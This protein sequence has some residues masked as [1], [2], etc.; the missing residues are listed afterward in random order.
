MTVSLTTDLIREQARNALTE[1]IGTGDITA[2]LIPDTASAKATVSCR[3]NAVICG[4]EWFNQVFA[5]LDTSI[6]VDWHVEDG[7]RVKSDKILCTLT[8]RARALLSGERT[9]LNFLQTLSG[10]ATAAARYVEAIKG[11]GVEILDTRKTIPGLRMAQKYA[12]RCGG[13][14]NHR[15]GLFDGVLI[16]ENHICAAG[17]IANAVAEARQIAPAGMPVEVEVENLQEAEEA[18]NAG[19][20]ILLLD[21]MSPPLLR[22][23]VDL[24]RGRAR[25]EASGGITLENIREIAETGIDFI[26]VGAITKD[27]SAVD[28]SM[29]FEPTV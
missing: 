23:A 10:T 19:V 16:K 6:H 5:L 18:L 20:D 22:N 4:C 29:R 11:T 26:S 27:V 25:L 17:S 7:Y 1:D 3:D 28:L 2:V 9:A 12:A 8:G 14:H 13:G 15:I 21:N 24:V